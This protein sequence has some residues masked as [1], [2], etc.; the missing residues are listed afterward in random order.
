MSGAVPV[1]FE[2][3]AAITTLV[4]LGQ[5][6]ELACT[7]PH[8]FRDPRTFEAIAQNS[9]AWFAPTAPKST[10][11][12]STCS[13]AILFACVLANESRSMELCSKVRVRWMNR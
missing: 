5:V 2:A 3:A 9:R 11:P 7:K 4:L 12:S 13:R 6:L 1:Y 8:V 10:S